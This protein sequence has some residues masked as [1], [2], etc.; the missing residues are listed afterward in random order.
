MM[1]CPKCG[2]E[3]RGLCIDCF[4]SDNLLTLKPM[5]V[6][7]C[8]CGNYIYKQLWRKDIRRSI[9]DIVKRSLVVPAGLKI[10]EMKT[11]PDF[12]EDK[13]NLKIKL[14]LE[15][16]GATSEKTLESSI[17]VGKTTCPDCVKVRSSY[18][19]A[20][21]QVRT[22][23]PKPDTLID[24]RFVTNAEE[25]RGGFDIFLTSTQYARKLEREFKEKGYMV[26]ESSKLFGKRDGRDIYRVSVLVKE[27]P[28]EAGDFLKHDGM[29]LRILRVGKR[30]ASIDVASRKELL[31][32]TQKIWDS[33]IVAKDSDAVEGIV[34][35]VTPSELQ[36]LDLLDNK[37]H[38]LPN[39][40]PELKAG[41]PVRLLHLGSK[42][43]IL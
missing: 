34:T 36:V 20:I 40:R 32:D 28:F 30:T 38:D 26:K 33:E 15:H 3:G 23:K 11:T 14:V 5:K 2:K 43:Y 37:T 19:E 8:G 41:E 4:L 42:V 7:L 9:D 17:A 22:T 6:S 27:P 16:N 31:L 21:L 12:K 35:M 25:V 24:S 10:K 18:F 1:F 29:V 13:I 39:N